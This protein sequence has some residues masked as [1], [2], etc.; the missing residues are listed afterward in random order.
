MSVLV[1]PVLV[2]HSWAIQQGSDEVLSWTH[3]LQHQADPIQRRQQE[4][5]KR[6]QEAAVIGLSHT[7]VYPTSATTDA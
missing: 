6:K 7:A 1:V 4:E 2:V 5:D 3:A